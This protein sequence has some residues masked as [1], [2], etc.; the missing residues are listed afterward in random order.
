MLT[1]LIRPNK[2]FDDLRENRYARDT[3]VFVIYR[4]AS[5]QVIKCPD[6]FR[7]PGGVTVLLSVHLLSSL[8]YLPKPGVLISDR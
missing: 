8:G 5:D 2:P 3:D 7:R 4:R 6:T 1:I